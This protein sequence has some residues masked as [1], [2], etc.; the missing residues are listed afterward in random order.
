MVNIHPFFAPA[1]VEEAVS[2]NFHGSYRRLQQLYAHLGK[3]FVVGESGWPSAGP[4]NG[5]AVPG[6]ENQRRFIHELARY[7]QTHA[8]SVFLFEMFDEPWKNEMG[9][10]GPHWGIFDRRGRAKFPLPVSGWSRP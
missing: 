10:I 6:L 3:P 5:P 4:P 2:A 7:A 8:V 9:G 1:A